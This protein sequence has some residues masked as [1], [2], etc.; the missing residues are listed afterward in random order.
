MSRLSLFFLAALC[1]YGGAKAEQRAICEYHW[2]AFGGDKFRRYCSQ[3]GRVDDI[4]EAFR[5]GAFT[6]RRAVPS[7]ANPTNAKRPFY[8]VC[9]RPQCSQLGEYVDF[10]Y[11]NAEDAHSVLSEWDKIEHVLQGSTLQDL[12]C[13]RDLRN[14][15]LLSVSPRENGWVLIVEKLPNTITCLYEFEF[16][17]GTVNFIDVQIAF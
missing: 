3:S 4:G 14:V 12:V 1:V 6:L 10:R 2:E 5:H 9:L 8:I 7:P 16:A 15:T 13:E 11:E 17:A